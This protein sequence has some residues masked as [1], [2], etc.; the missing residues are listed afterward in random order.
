MRHEILNEKG[1]RQV[2]DDIMGWLETHISLNR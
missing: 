2:W 1:K